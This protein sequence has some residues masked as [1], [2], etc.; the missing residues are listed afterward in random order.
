MKS[1]LNMGIGIGVVGDFSKS[2]PTAAQLVSLHRLVDYLKGYCGIP[3]NH[4]LLHRD[5]KR[6]ECPGRHFPSGMF[7]VPARDIPVAFR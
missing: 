2:R 5:V 4:V 1:P 6:T 7:L 3:D